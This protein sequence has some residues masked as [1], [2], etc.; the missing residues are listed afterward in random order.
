M[1]G[2]V[3]LGE[4]M[5]VLSATEPGPL[6]TGRTMRIGIAGAESN[7][8]IGVRRLGCP[9]TWIGRL[10]RDEWGELVRREL[11]AEGVTS[12]ASADDAPTGLMLKHRRTPDL[13]RV[14]YYRSGSAGSRLS[15]SDVPADAIAAARVLHVTGITPA[16]GPGPADAVR[17]AIRVAREAGVTVSLDVNYRAALW[18]RTEAGDLLRTL[19]DQVDVV[20]AGVA[21]ARLLIDGDTPADLANKL[22]GHGAEQVVVTLGAEGAYGLIHGDVYCTTAVEVSVTD[23]VGAGDAFVA[24]YLAEL[25][26]DSTP[27]QRMATASAAAAFAVATPGDWEGLPRRDELSLLRASDDVVR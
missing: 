12:L 15:P 21:E 16:L 26:T 5:A 13:T 6:A 17:H 20:F 22:A 2:L 11:R 19:L 4:T 25:I 9:A 8:A 14:D 24:G 27:A 18:S 23:P 10:G 1:T 3:T 7:V